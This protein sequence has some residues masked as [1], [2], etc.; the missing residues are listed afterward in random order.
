MVLKIF[1]IIAITTDLDK[2][3]QVFVILLK[4]K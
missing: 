4:K 3:F 2:S 1:N